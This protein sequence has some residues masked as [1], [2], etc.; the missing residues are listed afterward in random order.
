MTEDV[1]W[2]NRRDYIVFFINCAAGPS[3]KNVE[4]VDTILIVAH[5]ILTT[6]YKQNTRDTFIP[7]FM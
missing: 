5:S 6:N 3:T 4:F 2:L 1:E 7:S